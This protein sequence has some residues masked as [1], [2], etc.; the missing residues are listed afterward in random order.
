[1]LNLFLFISNERVSSS[2]KAD[3]RKF[4]IGP[5]FHNVTVEDLRREHKI[6]ME[7]IEKSGMLRTKAM[8]ERDE[9]LEL[10][11]YNYCLIR[12]RFPNEYVLQGLFKSSE[13]YEALYHFIQEQLQYDSVPFEL[14][15]HSLKKNIELSA[16]LAEVGLAPAAL[17]N[18]K[19]N[20]ASVTQA[21]QMNMNLK[22]YIKSSLIERAVNLE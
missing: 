9:Q 8:R 12:V 15:G 21:A 16:T 18:F 7:E 17:I 19:W 2:S 1:M 20:E 22:D 10:R 3:C 5:E 14:H 13:T 11:R 4:D 6:K